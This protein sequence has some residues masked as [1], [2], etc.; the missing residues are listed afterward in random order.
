MMAY[1][2]DLLTAA[3]LATATCIGTLLILFDLLL[4]YD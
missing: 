1:T 3:V 2:K 4:Q